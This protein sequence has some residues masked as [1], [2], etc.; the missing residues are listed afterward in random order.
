MITIYYVEVNLICIVFLA[1][2]LRQ[3][4][5]NGSDFS[6]D[7]SVL[8]QL[9]WVTMLFCLSDMAAGTLRGRMF[10]G[11]RALIELSNLL[12]L[13]TLLIISVLWNGYVRIRLSLNRALPHAYSLLRL[14]PAL[15]FTAL[16]ISNPWT[17]LLFKIDDSNLYERGSGIFTHWLVT[18]SYFLLP[19][20]RVLKLYL[21]ERNSIKREELA[22]MLYF[23]LA[24]AAASVVQMAFYGITS[25]QAGITLSIAL[26]CLSHQNAQVLTDSLTG[27]NNR[28]GFN[29]YLSDTAHTEA[30][31]PYVLAMID[32]DDFKNINDKY[33]HATGDAAL[34][35]VASALKTA[36][37][38]MTTRMFLCR[39]GGDEFAIF[40]E[41]ETDDCPSRLRGSIDAALKGQASGSDFPTALTV[42]IGIA[43]GSA[44][45]EAEFLA[46]LSD[47][48]HAMY[49]EKALKHEAKSGCQR[50]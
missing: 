12:Y 23:A 3:M 44:S 35:A 28:R 21:K 8:R 10:P 19:T 20:V 41:R 36:C 42:S 6:A 40:G 37:K 17:H 26:I 9:I 4:R 32:I 11:A 7:Q 49:E 24:P 45:N 43:C 30:E 25:T 48:D 34:K 22:P 33:G 2:F 38:S 47:A 39:Y 5:E 46:L 1:V 50:D 13:E 15:L 31:T 27:I 14:L 18:W 29:H 16:V